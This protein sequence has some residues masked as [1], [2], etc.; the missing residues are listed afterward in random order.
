MTKK[1]R[2]L[3]DG[4]TVTVNRNDGLR[5]RCECPRRSWT[6]CGHAWH[7]S[8]K[9]RGTTTHFRFPLDKYADKP[10]T[11]REGA[12]KERDRLRILIRDGAFP[13]SSTVT[14]Q[15]TPSDLTFEKFITVWRERAR[16]EL[17][18][19]AKANEAGIARKLG[20]KLLAPGETLSARPIARITEDDIEIAFGQ[21]KVKGST[22]NKYRRLILMAQRWV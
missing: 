17:D 6:T 21:L 16:T 22:W 12:L 3:K 13:P 14:S 20:S 1:I 5:K 2:T 11:T 7:F 4:R 18:D 19:E 15:A 8:F 9:P 10:I